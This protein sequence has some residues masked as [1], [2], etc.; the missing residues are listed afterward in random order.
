MIAAL[1]TLRQQVGDGRL[2]ALLAW[3]LAGGRFLQT[4]LELSQIFELLLAAP[5][6]EPGRARTRSRAGPA[7]RSGGCASSCSAN[8]HEPC[9]ATFAST[10]CSAADA[11]GSQGR[12]APRILVR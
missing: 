11:A 7:P 2:T 1:A 3:V 12:A 6:F 9:S 10:P 5:G 8:E 4:D